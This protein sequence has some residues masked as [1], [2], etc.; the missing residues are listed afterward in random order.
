MIEIKDE[1]FAAPADAWNR[2]SFAVNHHK[3]LLLWCRFGDNGNFFFRFKSAR[4]RLY[5]FWTARGENGGRVTEA[6][7]A[8][9]NGETI[10]D[11]CESWGDS[12]ERMDAVLS[13]TPKHILD[14]LFV[15]LD[16]IR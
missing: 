14:R 6:D 12:P 10:A 4:G 8:R 7:V 2:V 1:L 3:W 11:Y 16:A 5:S 15:L 9:A 13:L